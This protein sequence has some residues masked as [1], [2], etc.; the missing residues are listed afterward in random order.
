MCV[1]VRG[2]RR[3]QGDGPYGISMLRALRALREGNVHG[4]G[5]RTETQCPLYVST[6]T[7][8]RFSEKGEEE[9]EEE[10]GGGLVNDVQENE[11]D[12]DEKE[13]K[14]ITE[15][16]RAP[17]CPRRVRPPFRPSSCKILPVSPFL[18]H[19]PG[20]RVREIWLLE[21]VRTADIRRPAGIEGR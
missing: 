4:T 21:S 19:R 6:S 16:E 20:G 12:E 2:T 5:W 3:I 9:E 14:V 11:E 10:E 18:E 1:R 13:G 15:R 8:V 17:G 7:R